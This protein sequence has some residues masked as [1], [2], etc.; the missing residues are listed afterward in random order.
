MVAATRAFA[1]GREYRV[2]QILSSNEVAPSTLETANTL[3]AMH[4]KRMAPLLLPTPSGPQ[5]S[6]T[7]ANCHKKL[8]RSAGSI[9]API[10]GMG[11][12]DDALVHDR[13]QPKETTLS[14][15]IALLQEVLG[16]GIAPAAVYFLLVSGSLTAINKDT[17]EETRER[18]EAH[19]ERRLRPVNSGSGI[20]K[21]PLA[22]CARTG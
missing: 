13:G 3:R 5:L 19:L 20:L 16:K 4:P 2:S 1:I 18:L 8:L 14:W 15:W 7:R 9:R 11:Y 21:T 22:R 6:T 10:D 12:S 17:R